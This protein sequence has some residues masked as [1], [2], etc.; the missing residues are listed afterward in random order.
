MVHRVRVEAFKLIWREQDTPLVALNLSEEVLLL[1]IVSWCHIP[2]TKKETDNSHV[3][4]KG[5]G[6]GTG[7]RPHWG[8]N[9]LPYMSIELNRAKDPKALYKPGITAGLATARVKVTEHFPF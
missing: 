5:L 9:E 6:K 7:Y 2:W 1:I 3:Y 4:F 8:N